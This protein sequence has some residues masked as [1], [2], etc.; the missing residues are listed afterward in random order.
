MSSAQDNRERHEEHN[1]APLYS[2]IQSMLTT[3]TLAIREARK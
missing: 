3:L 2:N 1:Q